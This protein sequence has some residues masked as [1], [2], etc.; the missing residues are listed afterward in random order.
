MHL[1]TFR[2]MAL[3]VSAV[4]L[5][6][7]TSVLAAATVSV[8]SSGNSYTLMGSGMDGASGIQLDIAYDSASLANPTVTQGSLI[9]GAIFQANT[10]RAGSIKIA[11]ISTSAFPSSGP[12]ATI[13]FASRTG[14][15]GITSV[16]PLVIDSKGSA[17][18]ASA[19]APSNDTLNSSP[20]LPLASTSSPLPNQPATANQTTQSPTTSSPV[21]A[22]TV[23]IPTDQQQQRAE[24]QQAAASPAVPA[25]P[26]EQQPAK[27]AEQAPQSS[28]P[29]PEAKPDETPQLVVYKGIAERFKHYSGS[30][31]LAAMVK[32]FDKKIA[33]A[34]NQE[35]S[36]LISDGKNKA[37]LSVDIPSRI[38]SSPNFAVN[39]G[40]LVSYKK[41]RQ[42]KGRWTVV[43]Q[44]NPGS[45]AVSIT[46]I[47]GTEEL[48]YPL[49]AVQ[50]IKTA[51]P[52]DENGWN[53]FSKEVGT[54]AVPQH[55][56]NNDGVRNYLDEYI[57][58]ANYLVNR[59]TPPAKPAV[60]VKKTA[61]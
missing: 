8:T 47:T 30:K 51:L 55:D 37:T 44:P 36:I 3:L 6:W 48:E 21:F 40:T 25:Y 12:I 14:N 43:V 23:S 9:S 50:P 15:G 19:S 46:I 11:V 45:N 35:P 52:L 32:L 39:G 41:D 56:L 28:K 38:T 13:T 57:F 5:S 7:A 18:S 1:W 49:T 34:V 60:P 58:V 59:K 24:S 16:V 33:Q 31:T 17:I 29:L 22:G 26:V 61:K 2:R 42:V 20:F 53:R 27:T 10:T 54:A 4:V